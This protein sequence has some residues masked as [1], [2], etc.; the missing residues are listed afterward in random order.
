MLKIRC[1]HL[2]KLST[3][4]TE[5]IPTFHERNVQ[6]DMVFVVQSCN[7][8]IHCTESVDNF[9]EYNISAKCGQPFIV[10]LFYGY[11]L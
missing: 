5:I 3:E 7:S 9:N 1:P 11:G 10:K 8:E 6:R 4:L 2:L